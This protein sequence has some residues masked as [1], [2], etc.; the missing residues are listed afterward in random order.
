[1]NFLPA[2]YMSIIVNNQVDY[3]FFH[4]KWQNVKLYG[5]TYRDRWNFLNGLFIFWSLCSSL[6]T[7]AS[8]SVCLPRGNRV[9]EICIPWPWCDEVDEKARRV[10]TVQKFSWELAMKPQIAKN[11]KILIFKVFF[12]LVESF[13]FFLS[14]KNI[15][16]NVLTT[17]IF[18]SILFT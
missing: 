18:K 17:L 3:D 14:F 8:L 12:H 2:K 16:G 15:N 4:I 10:E 5:E 7:R 9:G 6:L 1:M 13:H 11:L